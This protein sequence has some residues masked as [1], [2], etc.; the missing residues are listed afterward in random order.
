VKLA[1]SAGTYVEISS[2]EQNHQ[3][4][5]NRQFLTLVFFSTFGLLDFSEAFAGAKLVGMLTWCVVNFMS[6]VGTALEPIL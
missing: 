4:N 2:N 3:K 5:F 1:H 6:G